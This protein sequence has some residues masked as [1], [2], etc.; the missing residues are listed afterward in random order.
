MKHAKTFKA[1]VLP[2]PLAVFG[3]AAACWAAVA[4]PATAQGIL[5]TPLPILDVE[6][7][8]VLLERDLVLE[9]CAYR[10]GELLEPPLAP[11]PG[12]TGLRG[13]SAPAAPSVSPELLE[14]DL[15]CLTLSAGG[16]VINRSIGDGIGFGT[17]PGAAPEPFFLLHG[18]HLWGGAANIGVEMVTEQATFD[19]NGFYSRVGGS[20]FASE[21]I[22]GGPVAYTFGQDAFGSTGLG[23]GAT[24]AEASSE[25]SYSELGME[26]DIM[27]LRYLYGADVGPNGAP[28]S[29]LSVGLAT[30]LSHSALDQMG[31]FQSLTFPD[32]RAE[33]DRRLTTNA[34]GIGPKLAAEIDLGSFILTSDVSLQAVWRQ[35]ELNS[36][37]AITCGACGGGLPGA[38]NINIAD[39]VSGL[40]WQAG[41]DLGVEAALN[42]GL[43]L[44]L[45]G[46]LDIGGRDTIRV[47]ENPAEPITG[48]ERI[49]AVDWGIGAGIKGRF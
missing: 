27:A 14:A 6:R 41:L 33:V 9:Y 16:G 12:Q 17:V 10:L 24:G 45:D 29:Q 42:R 7:D 32:I 18:S 31:T 46:S 1:N 26:A 39:S 3:L 20:A 28:R 43:T 30:M 19:W 11:A 49:T 25:L 48:I 37:E 4:A 40:D 44:Y 35:S 15:S 5:D 21:P 38:F 8:L 13:L 47:R 22:G 34:I 36:Q 2:A 23:L